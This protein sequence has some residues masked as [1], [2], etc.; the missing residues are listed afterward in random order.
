[1]QLTACYLYPVKSCAALPLPHSVVEPRGLRGDRRWMVVD[2]DFRFITGRQYPRMTRVVAE[3]T[4]QGVRL[5]APGMPTLDVARPPAD[6]PVT[7]EIWKTPVGATVAAPDACAWFSAYLGIDATLVHMDDTI[8]RAVDPAFARPGDI[9][10]YADSFPLMLL[11]SASL[12]G[13]NAR[14]QQ[15]VPMI[16]FR[17]NLVV[18][19]ARPHEEDAWTRIAIGDVEFDVARACTRCNFVNVD[20]QRGERV[21]T[22]EP[23][24]TLTG[25]RRV[26]DGVIFGRHLIPRS[27]G[28][29][30]VGDR[31][32]VLAVQGG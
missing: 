18:D 32:E 14:L 5:S 4:A 23:L 2:D 17:P 31:V 13:L 27:A 20:P 10:G 25:Y 22:G 24:R 30:R 15:P 11:G 1:M 26:E 28:T 19:T 16:Q 21:A 7:A 3:P 29:I 8:E 6:A 9:V 12:D